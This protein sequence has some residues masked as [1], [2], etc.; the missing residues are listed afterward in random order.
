MFSRA[1]IDQLLAHEQAPAISF[2]LPTHGAGLEVRQDPVR[3]RNLRT[4]A[5]ERLTASGMRAPDADALIAPV[6]RLIEDEVFW[7]QQDKGLAVFLSPGFFQAFTLCHTMPERVV[8]GDGFDL[9]PLIP[10]L[11]SHRQFLVLAMSAEETRLYQA[12]THGM[13]RVHGVDI[14]MGVDVL[15]AETEAQEGRKVASSGG[16]RGRARGERGIPADRNYGDT[17]EELRQARFVEYLHKVANAVDSWIGNRNPPMVLAAQSELRGNFLAVGRF[18]SDTAELVEVD[19]NPFGLSEDDLHA[20]ALAAIGP[21]LKAETL[22]EI[23]RFYSLYNDG[24]ARSTDRPEGFVRAARFQAVDVL[25]V[26]DDQGP[27]WGRY[28]EAEDTVHVNE[29]KQE[30]DEDL[31]ARAAMDTLRGGG[32]VLCVSRDELRA[33]SRSM[34]AGAILRFEMTPSPRGEA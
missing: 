15:D 24:S 2:Y 21:V 6:T 26:P 28:D 20:R 4:R 13:V 32:R 33:G 7:R 34:P 27:V 22:R 23:D 12:G 18:G 3:L 8:V 30:G 16:P 5:I 11:S 17:P 25:L 31:I 19:V 29:E 14:P 1:D 10:L 9:M